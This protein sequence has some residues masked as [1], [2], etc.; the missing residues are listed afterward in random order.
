VARIGIESGVGGGNV[1]SLLFNVAHFSGS[2]WETTKPGAPSR[3]SKSDEISK[4]DRRNGMKLY[5]SR[6]AMALLQRKREANRREPHS[7]NPQILKNAD[8]LRGGRGS[9]M[10]PG[11][12]R[13]SLLLA[14]CHPPLTYL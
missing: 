8:P 13:L 6:M 5:R 2:D 14:S 1:A 11:E 10:I 12:E 3:E 4:V 7:E 9:T